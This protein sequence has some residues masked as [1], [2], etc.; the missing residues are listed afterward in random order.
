[1]QSD[2]YQ[3]K[4]EA[5]VNSKNLTGKCYLHLFKKFARYKILCCANDLAA[6]LC[7]DADD[8]TLSEYRIRSEDC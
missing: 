7:S 1:M 8:P 3:L 4:Q 5:T 2:E 6:Q